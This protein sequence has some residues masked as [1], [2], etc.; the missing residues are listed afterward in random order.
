[1]NLG[2]LFLTIFLTGV[3]LA[4]DYCIKWSVGS[5]H[6]VAFL[7]MAGFLWCSSIY[8]WYITV[9]DERIAIVGALFSVLSLVGTILI[10]IIGFNE[11]LTLKEWVGFSLGI[12]AVILLSGKL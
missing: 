7:V 1:M 12:V 4:G 6:K 2:I 10:G 11:H 5:S 3:L 8:G 9:K